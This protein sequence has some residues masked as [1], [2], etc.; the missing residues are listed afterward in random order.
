MNKV[1]SECLLL[2]RIHVAYEVSRVPWVSSINT[3]IMLFIW[4]VNKVFMC[5]G[6]QKQSKAQWV[7]DA[8]SLWNLPSNIPFWIMSPKNADLF[9]CCFLS[10]FFDF[11]LNTHQFPGDNIVSVLGEIETTHKQSIGC[12]ILS[13]SELLSMVYVR[14]NHRIMYVMELYSCVCIGL[15]FVAN[16]GWYAICI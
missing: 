11:P 2:P 15:K 8:C 9:L 14:D 4:E 16:W 3:E 5:V 6:M 12:H 10:L 13:W 1:K 7:I